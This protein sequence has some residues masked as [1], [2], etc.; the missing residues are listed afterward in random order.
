M[1]SSSA[2]GTGSRPGTTLAAF[3]I[4][5]PLAAGLLYAIHHAPMKSEAIQTVRRYVTHPVQWAVVGLFCCAL[6]T[7]LA[8]LSQSMVERRACRLLSL[9]AWDGQ[10]APATDANR[11]AGCVDRLSY[12][13][14]RTFIARRVLAVLDFLKQRQSATGLDDHLRSLADTDGFTLETSYALTRFITWAIP[15]LGFLGTVL[16]ITAAIAGVK[17]DD[18]N[19][20]SVTGGLAEAFD[21]T[22]LALGLTMVTMFCSFLVERAEQGVLEYVDQYVE[23]QLA[24]RFQNREVETHTSPHVQELVDVAEKLVQRQAELWAKTFNEKERQSAELQA[25]QQDRVGTA[26]EKAL[27]RTLQTHTQRLAALEKQAVEQSAHLLE[28]LAAVAAAMRD[29]G[30]EHQAAL[31]HVGEMMAA[32]A[33]TLAQIQAGERQLIQLQTVMHENLSALAGAGAFEQAV[34]NLTAAVHLLTSR[35]L[36]MQV[37]TPLHPAVPRTAV[38]KAA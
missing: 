32:Q 16:G 18:L 13:L 14:R 4:G 24:H 2:A 35:T 36:P 28:N 21:S 3:L 26:L 17:T 25:R 5:L 11:L 29:T 20:S 10:P 12:R 23:A 31:T 22:A 27:E 7:L 30:R 37:A 15:I 9:P 34:H 38:G 6:G 1:S 33:A 8:K 19:L